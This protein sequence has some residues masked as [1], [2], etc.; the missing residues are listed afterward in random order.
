VRH[1]NERSTG[2]N[3]QK[4][5]QYAPD[6]IQTDAWSGTLISAS[7]SE[8]VAKVEIMGKTLIIDG[9]H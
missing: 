9:N 8:G 4:Y 5:K 6:V 1:N 3:Y 7:F 2:K